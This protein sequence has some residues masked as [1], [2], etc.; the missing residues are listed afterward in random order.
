ML[1]AGSVQ[2]A[3]RE[4]KLEEAP[5]PSLVRDYECSNA[6]LSLALGFNPSR[7]VVHAV[8]E[9]LSRIDLSDLGALDDPRH[10]NIRWLEQMRA[11]L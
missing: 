1:V 7:S 6:K 4:V 9:L 2:L 5:L 11:A 8:E 3:G 10:Y